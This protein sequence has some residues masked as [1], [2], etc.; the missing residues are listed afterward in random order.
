MHD[1]GRILPQFSYGPNHHAYLS[2]RINEERP[3]LPKL[4]QQC[5]I[6]RHGIRGQTRQIPLADQHGVTERLNERIVGRD[7]DALGLATLHPLMSEGE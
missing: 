3:P 5:R 4:A 2:L 7:W 6:D 1:D